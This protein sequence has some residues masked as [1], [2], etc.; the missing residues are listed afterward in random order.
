VTVIDK[1]GIER[2]F[3]LDPL[4]FL[5][6]EKG[7]TFRTRLKNLF[8]QQAVQKAQQA[9]QS[10]IAMYISEYEHGLLDHDH[11]VMYNTGFIGEQAFHLDVGK[12]CKRESIRDVQAYKQD[13][14][15]VL[16]KI[17]EWVE[18]FYPAY[19]SSISCFLNQKYKEHTGECCV[20]ETID[21]RKFKKTYHQVRMD[22]F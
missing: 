5:I 11:G 17:Y 1:L 9:I 18:K 19:S 10:I 14:K 8:D 22:N 7:E 6:Q 15:Q 21:P 20:M 3:E 13:L 2:S 4:V 16:W 12:L